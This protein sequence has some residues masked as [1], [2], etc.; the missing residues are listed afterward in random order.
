MKKTLA[1]IIILAALCAVSRAEPV[2]VT[3]FLVTPS[4]NGESGFIFAPSAYV[5]PHN[6]FAL[7]IHKFVFKANY[8]LFD[9]LEAGVNFDFTGSLNLLEI[10]KAG[11]I[12]V[13]GRILKEEDFF[14]SLAAGLEKLPMNLFTD[15]KGQ[16][17]SGYAVVSKS[18]DD[19]DVSVGFKK[20]LAGAAQDNYI[21]ADFAKVINETI[22][23]IAEYNTGGINAGV[24]ISLNSNI[25]VE[26][27]F[28]GLENIG[29]ANALGT[30][31]R[32]NFI[33]GITYIQ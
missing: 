25:N 5:P 23:A 8:G 13:K 15:I 27:Y 14:I 32:E 33:F 10:L 7:G 26:V 12:N 24:K 6:T 9:I 22:L 2:E 3:H 1:V 16:D 30:F 20:N 17:F 29:N 28:S 4:F 19:M 18:I 31:L 21:M 11:D